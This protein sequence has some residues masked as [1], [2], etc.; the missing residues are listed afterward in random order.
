MGNKHKKKHSTALVMRKMQT[1][2][3]M[4]SYLNV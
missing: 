4:K 1:K 2:I 3:T